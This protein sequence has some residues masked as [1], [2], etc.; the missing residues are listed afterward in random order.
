MKT[1]EQ[2]VDETVECLKNGGVILYPTDTIWGL[3]CDAT[4]PKAIEKIYKIKQ[5]PE[6][7]SLIILLDQIEHLK[8]Y[9]KE[10]PLFA[11]ELIKKAENPLSI[12]YPNAKNLAKN[13]V[14]ANGTICIRVTSNMFC[15]DVIKKFGKPITSTSANISQEK[16]PVFYTQISDDI[17]NSVDYIV[18]LYQNIV[19]EPKASTIIKIELD[20]S[21]QIIRL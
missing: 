12:I 9:V 3:G 4:K 11:E 1:Y 16:S 5:R 7:K 2:I 21:Y 10:V 14:A 8:D 20:G 13:V 17:K 6:N 15:K 18:D 19:N